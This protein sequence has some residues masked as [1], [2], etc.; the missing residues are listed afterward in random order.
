LQHEHIH[1]R[2]QRELLVLPFYLLYLLHYLVN[3]IR[4]RNHNKAYRHIC[5]ERE[6]YACEVQA[7][8]LKNRKWMSWISY[9]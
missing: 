1:L 5:F 9:L 8:Y 4:Y 2:Q 6:A 7:D 3:I